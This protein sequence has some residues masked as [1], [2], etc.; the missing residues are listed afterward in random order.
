MP[1]YSA[2]SMTSVNRAS[3]LA[4]SIRQFHIMLAMAAQL[5]V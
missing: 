3:P 2:L 1:L 4:A 5:S